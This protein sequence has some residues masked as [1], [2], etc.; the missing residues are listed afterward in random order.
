M[1]KRRWSC[2]SANFPLMHRGNP[3]SETQGFS[4]LARCCLPDT[5]DGGTGSTWG[6]CEITVAGVHCEG[7]PL[8]P[9]WPALFLD[10]SW[11]RGLSLSI[12][13]FRDSFAS[14]SC[15]NP[16]LNIH[17]DA[18]SSFL[19]PNHLAVHGNAFAL[20]AMLNNARARG[21]CVI[22]SRR[23]RINPTLDVTGVTRE[24]IGAGHVPHCN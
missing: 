15:V 17:P 23:F 21:R 2:L 9:R 5:G 6:S 20:R 24:K 18:T 10:G 8:P 11:R 12:I 14:L 4:A 7:L 16:P 13:P 19:E 22:W 1:L 3:L